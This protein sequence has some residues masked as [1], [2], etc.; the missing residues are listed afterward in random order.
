MQETISGLSQGTTYYYRSVAV[1]S[2]GV[3]RSAIASF[4]TQ[5]ERS[6]DV[7][8][9]DAENSFSGE[10]THDQTTKDTTDKNLTDSN[11]SEDKEDSLGGVFVWGS[12]L[13]EQFFTIDEKGNIDTG[14]SFDETKKEKQNF[15][16]AGALSGR[17]FLPDTWS[18]WGLTI[19]ILYIVISRTYYFFKAWKKRKKEDK[20]RE[21]EMQR[22][23]NQL[24][25][26][27]NEQPNGGGVP[28]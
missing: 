22:A 27:Q 2:A 16:L 5:G 24:S 21:E 7:G 1:T 18:E 17:K 9:A 14:V 13:R 12:T 28:A 6:D 23:H 15:L 19:V 20:E 3:N 11:D 26:V 10:D 4:T 8:G 25:D